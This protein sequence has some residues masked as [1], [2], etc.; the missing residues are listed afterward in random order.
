MFSIWFF[1]NIALEAL[2]KIGRGLD[3]EVDFIIVSDASASNKFQS[4]KNLA[5]LS[6]M[7]RLLDIAMYQV[8]ALRSREFHAAVVEKGQGAYLRISGAARNYHTTLHTPCKADFDMILHNGY[9]T[10]KEAA[11]E[12]AKDNIG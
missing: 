11:K 1:R 10:A 12:T 8:Y 4:Y 6:N 7:K 3:S 2:Y 5:S 9:E